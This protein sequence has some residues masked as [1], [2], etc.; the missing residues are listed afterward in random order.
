MPADDLER[1]KTQCVAVRSPRGARVTN[2]EWGDGHKGVYPHA[3][4]R[5]YCPC[6][7][8]QGHSGEI[9]FVPKA[10]GPALELD[11]IEPVGAYA[12]RL[13]WFDGHGG[14]LYSF[15]YLRS[16]CQCDECRAG[17]DPDDRPPRAR[18]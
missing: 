8:C 9:K 16:L 11:E 17:Q 15:R 1:K 18:Q 10:D 13:V 14:G 2:I 5:G 6:A 4:L 7:E 3:V 12:L